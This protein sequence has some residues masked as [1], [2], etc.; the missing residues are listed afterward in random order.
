[1]ADNINKSRFNGTM[2]F[3]SAIEPAWHR[4]GTILPDKFT[5]EEAIRYANMGY[6]VALAPIYAK[7]SNDKTL[8]EEKRVCKVEGNFA[9]YRT[10]TLEVFGVVGDRYRVIQN[11]A[12]FDFFDSIVG[13]GK[14][15]YET[16]GV[17][18]KGETIFL[19][20]KLPDNIILPGN[21]IVER[22]LVFTMGHDGKT[23]VSCLF[24]PT[25]VV[26]ANTLAVA[27][28]NGINKV[29]IKHTNSAIDKIKEAGKLMGL[30]HKTS[31][32]TTEILNAM[33]KVRINDDQ[34]TEYIKLVFLTPDE[35]K[36][37]AETGDH[38]LAE[39]ATRTI[40]TMEQIADFTLTGVGQDTLS[41]KGTLF[42]AY[43]GVTGWLFNKKEYKT[44]DARMQNLIFEGT[45]YKLNNKAFNIATELINEWR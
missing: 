28:G 23:P 20:A 26:C 35:R 45:D 17:L 5:S 15:I 9:S 7:F 42:G 31:G 10:D 36:R 16:A 12:A 34:L 18:G 2:S 40:G 41:T 24:T 44:D 33:A 21:D 30:V 1:M 25:R 13:E 3:V 14:A 22:Y 4:K 11:V 43:S 39:I 8:P 29:V 38:R 32:A 37:L 6:D 27:L 19:T